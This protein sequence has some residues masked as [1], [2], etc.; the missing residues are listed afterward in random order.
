[1]RARPGATVAALALFGISAVGYV[2]FARSRNELWSMLDLDVY[3]WGGETARHADDLYRIKYAG[4]LSFTYPPFAA[5]LFVPLA[6]LPYSVLRYA[7]TTT[8]L[9]LVW[10]TV[11]WT[12]G[13][14]GRAPD[15]QRVIATSL[16][17]ALFVWLEPVQ[18]TLRFGQINLLLMALLITDLLRP[19]ER[20]AKGV[21]V[22]VAAGLKLT[23]LIFVAY[24]VLTRRWHAARI[25][26]LTFA[27]TIVLGAV[28]LPA[29]SKDFWGDRLF[30]DS[31]RV[32]GVAFVS[33]QSLHGMVTR[34]A[35]SVD[36]GQ[37]WWWACAAVVG[38]AG[39]AL[40][41][42]AHREGREV[43]GVLLCAVTGLLVSPISW[44]HHWVWVVPLLTVAAHRAAERRSLRSALFTGGVV[45]LLFAWF[46]RERPGLPLLP[47]GVIWQ[48]PAGGLEH[49]WNTWQVLY[50][51]LY[52]FGG[53]ALLV[54][55]FVLLRR[56]GRAYMD[57]AMLAKR[58]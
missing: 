40:A 37:S 19:D 54:F 47:R 2:L 7:L 41:V 15:Q 52:V 6:S 38:V 13:A 43:A 46:S 29:E 25:A 50:G 49:R 4:F 30:M 5:A 42:W 58:V 55:A 53:L 18:Q 57:R 51:N 9:V 12:F 10:W 3:R 45:L 44:S 48:A 36:A 35:G 1:V 26:L 32:G 11:W 56:D 31:E 16:L 33:N 34:L 23:P 21:G 22:G 28:A 8:G 14:L 24:L 39:M 20:R 27:G 17:A